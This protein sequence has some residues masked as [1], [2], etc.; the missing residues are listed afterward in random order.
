MRP[1]V[2]FR[3]RANTAKSRICTRRNVAG[4]AG[5]LPDFIAPFHTVYE[6][7][8]KNEVESAL[9]YHDW[10]SAL[11]FG[12]L[13]KHQT[14]FYATIERFVELCKKDRLPSYSFIEPR[15]NPQQDGGAFL[16]A[17]DQHPDHDVAAGEFLI[18]RVYE[19]LRANDNVWQR[20]MLVIIY[21]EH[22]GLYDHIPPPRC[23]S[24]DGIVCS[25]PAFDFTRLGPR[26]PAVIISPY[27]SPGTIVHDPFDHTSAIATAMKLLAPQAWPSDVMGKRAQ[28]A[29]TFEGVMDT[30]MSPRADT[31][32]F[33]APP[34]TAAAPAPLSSLQRQ[35]LAHAA[36][37]ESQLPPDQRTGIDP[38][39]I[40]DEH[41]AGI[42]LREISSKLTQ[43]GGSSTD[44]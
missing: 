38:Q 35:A 21:D 43:K 20:S 33:T 8:W 34:V 27:I 13:L 2:L 44:D 3:A 7:L 1:L 10:S 32:N 16:P 14:Q 17:N 39:S 40:Q 4:A 28:N 15:Y 23:V 6:V 26:V 25:S 29:N 18:K 36:E 19:A 24:P 42:Y 11:G 12:F 9:F 37:L 41:Q 31:P 5:P 22:G 30:N